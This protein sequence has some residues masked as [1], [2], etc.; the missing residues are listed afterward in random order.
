V[1]DVEGEG[2][3]E[4]VTLGD[5]DGLDGGVTEGVGEDATVA[6]SSFTTIVLTATGLTGLGGGGQ[7]TVTLTVV[8]VGEVPPP[9]TEV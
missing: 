3:A 5:G 6:T 1:A 8:Y 9:G 2:E 4:V 7:V